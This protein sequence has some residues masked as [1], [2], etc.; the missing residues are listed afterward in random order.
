MAIVHLETARCRECDAILGEPGS[1]SFV[2]G[3]AGLPVAFD[4]DDPPAEMTVELECPDGHV[5]MLLV[6]NE[7]S[8]EET[9]VIPDRAPIGAD[10]RLRSGTTESG[11]PL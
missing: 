2:V 5:T 4:P 7:V 10:A 11:K 1:R 8:A 6:P 3:K 9:L